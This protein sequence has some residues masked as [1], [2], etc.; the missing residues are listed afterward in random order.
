MQNTIWNERLDLLSQVQTDPQ[1]ANRMAVFECKLCFY[2][3]HLAGQAFT[4]YNCRDCK[5]TQMHSN[6]RVPR[7]C[8]LCA[9]NTNCCRRCRNDVNWK[10]EE[11]L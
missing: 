2:G 10:P 1:H 11:H 4:K 7:L 8:L 5:V 3:L 6:T 9:Q